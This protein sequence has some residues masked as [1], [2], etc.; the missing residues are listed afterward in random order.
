[1][2]RIG[3]NWRKTTDAIIEMRKENPL[4]FHSTELKRLQVE[5]GGKKFSLR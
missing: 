4:N 3:I 1:L 2:N 5:M